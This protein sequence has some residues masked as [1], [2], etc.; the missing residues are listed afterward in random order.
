MRG[1][2]SNSAGF[3][4]RR[5]WTP[6]YPRY[7]VAIRGIGG[8]D[9]RLYVVNLFYQRCTLAARSSL[10]YSFFDAAGPT[11]LYE[12]IRSLRPRVSYCFIHR[13][14]CWLRYCM[15]HSIYSWYIYVIR[16]ELR[17]RDI[18]IFRDPLLG[19]VYVR[20]SRDERYE[21][22]FNFMWEYCELLFILHSIS[23]SLFLS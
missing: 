8:K 22:I 21:K 7:R 2:Q 23:L 18:L 20:Y 1:T 13:V 5:P 6:V 9:R 16:E 19:Y 10:S 14:S 15:Y 12:F 4:H 3:M 17:E 11:N